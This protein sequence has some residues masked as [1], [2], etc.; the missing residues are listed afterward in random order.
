M[1]YYAYRLFQNKVLF[2]IQ[3]NR[4]QEGV[5]QQQYRFL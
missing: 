2:Y 1:L 5:K 3:I 4:L